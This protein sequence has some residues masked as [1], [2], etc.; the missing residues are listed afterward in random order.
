MKHSI[1]LLLL[2]V[3]TFSI[4]QVQYT[5]QGDFPKFPNSNYE[6]KGYE[7]LQQKTLSVAES[8]E[9]GVFTLTYPRAYKGVAQLWMNGAYQVLLFLNQ[10]NIT[11]HWEDLTNRDNLQ[12]NSTEYEAFIGGMKAFQDSEAKL[13]GLQD[14]KSTRLNS[15]H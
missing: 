6:L 10:E 1:T 11:L 13:A 9:N 12:A 14:R 8:K 5:I 15:S 4:A 2:S 3:F 7:G